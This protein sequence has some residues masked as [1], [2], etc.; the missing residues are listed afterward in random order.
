MCNKLVI[1]KGKLDKLSITKVK[2]W[3]VYFTYENKMSRIK[4]CIIYGTR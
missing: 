3:S 2:D 1:N 4:M